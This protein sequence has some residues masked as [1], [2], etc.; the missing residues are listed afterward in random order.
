MHLAVVDERQGDQEDDKA[1]S[2]ADVI[3]FQYARMLHRYEKLLLEEEMLHA[4]LEGPH[5]DEARVTVFKSMLRNC[6]DCIARELPED[7]LPRFLVQ[8]EAPG[9]YASTV[10]HKCAHFTLTASK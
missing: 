8:P 9:E 4:G 7:L 10:L 3:R 5:V 6:V 2:I 1:V